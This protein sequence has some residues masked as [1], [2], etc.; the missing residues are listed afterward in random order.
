MTK[1]QNKIERAIVFGDLHCP[2][3]CKKSVN[4]LLKYIRDNEWDYMVIL[5]DF[6]DYF[7]IARYNEEK[8][9]LVEGTT[10]L[11]EG[12]EGAKLLWDFMEAA[13]NKNPKV[14]IIYL[15]GNHEYRATEFAYKN[16][17][18]RGIIEPENLLA[19]NTNEIV[20]FKTWSQDEMC[21]IGNA[22]FHHGRYT[23]QY[24]SKKHVD[25]Y[26]V[27]IFYGHT[28]TVQQHVRPARKDESVMIGQSLGCL[29]EYPN[30]YDYMKGAP[31]NWQK[32]FATF[33]FLPDGQFNYYVTHIRD[34]K[35]ISPDGKL[36]T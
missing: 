15:E 35:F 18:L 7:C 24:H 28:H 8:P 23:N 33:H 3:H 19:F 32:A 14:E 13:R 25:N 36:Y 5:G 11:K 31:R 6:M 4:V 27:N 10:V 34:G 9:G 2:F 29:C 17:H 1:K 20:Y 12:A 16:P 21:R 26:G 22:F 30:K